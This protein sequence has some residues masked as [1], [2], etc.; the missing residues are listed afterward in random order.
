M[1]LASRSKRAKSKIAVWSTLAVLAC[2]MAEGQLTKSPSANG[3]EPP[4]W[5]AQQD[6][7]NMMD[8][9][10]I[11]ALRPGPS[12]NEKAPNHANYDESNANPF[13]D[14]P[15]ALTFKNG[16][17]VTTAT[18]WQQRRREIVEDF[19]REVLGAVP[20][21]VPKVTWDV[22]STTNSKEGIF[23]VVK[24]QLAG[25][26]DNSGCPSIDVNIE[27]TLVTPANA[28]SPVP[29]M[30]MFGSA[31][32]L[33]RMADMTAS[34]PELKAVMG[35]DPPSSEQLIAGGWGYA[36]IDP[37][38]IQPDNGA[39]LTKGIIGLANQGKPRKPEDWGA[40]R[41]WAWGASR[42]LDYL[43]TDKA[44]DGKRV[45]IEGVS[46]YGKAALVTMA[47]DDR[48]A[49]VLVG[50]S[51]EGGAKPHRRNFGEAVE[52]LTGSGEYHWMAGNFLKYGAAEATFGSRNAGNLPVDSNELIALCAPRPTFIS[53]GIP[54][55]GD[56]RWLD[57]TGSFMAAVAAGPVFRLLGANDLG[58]RDD[59]HT[60]K[61]PPVNAGLLGG[62]LAWRQHD[63]GHTDAPNW[64]YFI[65]WAD[66][67][68][69]YHAA[70]W[71]FPADQPIFRTDPNSLVAH[72]QL[73]AKAKQD[74]IDVYFEGD[75]ITRRWGATDYPDLLASWKQNFFGWNAADFGWGADRTQNILW[76]LQNGELDG[77]NPKV[78]ILLA[79]TNNIGNETVRGDAESGADDLTRGLQAIVDV[80]HTK[81]PAAT[82]IVMGIFP[83]NDNM[84]FMPVIDKINGNLS[85]LADGR[86]VRYLNIN[87][88]LADADGRLFE[89][90]MNAKDKLHPTVKAYQVWAD[91]LK[92]V[93]TELLGPRAAVDHAPPPTGDPGASR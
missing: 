16:Q 3:C 45:G 46:R 69:N 88:K 23:P 49:V 87:D 80:I 33:R 32:F 57:Q 55:K 65:P 12:G 17:R 36:L 86:Q 42:G 85:R 30:M 50:S 35:S 78:V 31:A 48:F 61:M 76:R 74:G 68:L 7:Q 21:N 83:R 5:T 15:D 66:K 11:Q 1:N 41:A 56:A 40:L 67:F 8:Q 14:L 75:S 60:A 38:S 27:M 53:Y 10:G 84:A 70:S 47:F 22:T 25:H 71:R 9:L 77:L 28:K 81:A 90:M 19:E 82:I 64:K 63:G 62:Q 34:R 6:H 43:Q 52:N 13:P 92:P 18:G 93:L 73:L 4:N 51:G 91:A 89:G 44:V 39:G 54:E 26:A 59:Y 72:S 29:V 20:P 2:Q 58:V 37:G 79:G 24:K